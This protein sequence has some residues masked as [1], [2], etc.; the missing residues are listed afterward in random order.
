M[1]GFKVV[2]NNEHE[3]LGGIPEGITSVILSSKNG[4]IELFFGSSDKTG[5]I[6][7]TWAS[8]TLSVGDKLKIIFQDVDGKFNPVNIIDYT[9]EDDVNKIELESYHRL[10]KELRDEGLIQ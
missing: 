6:S 4:I 5:M 3:F 8:F 10:Q 7:Y 2:L 1:R 9:N